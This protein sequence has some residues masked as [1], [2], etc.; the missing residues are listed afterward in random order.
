LN[1]ITKEEENVTEWLKDQN[2]IVFS[3]K[4][5][6]TPL[7]FRRDSFD[8]NILQLNHIL[9][10]CDKNDS[11]YAKQI[12]KNVSNT[13][14]DLGMFN[15]I[16]GTV[17]NLEKFS[18]ILSEGQT[19]SVKENPEINLS[20]FNGEMRLKMNDFNATFVEYSGEK[21]YSH[22]THHLVY[23]SDNITIDEMKHIAI[24]DQFFME[25]A[26]RTTD[27]KTKLY[28][29]MDSPYPIAEGETMTVPNYISTTT[30]LES[31]GE[32]RNGGVITFIDEY[33]YRRNKRTIM[34]KPP[35]LPDNLHNCCAY[36]LILDKDIPYVDME[37][38]TEIVS[39]KE[40]LLPR[41]LLITLI[42]EYITES[43]IHVRQLRVSKTTE[44]QFD[45]IPKNRCTKFGYADVDVA[46]IEFD[47]SSGGCRKSRHQKNK[48]KS[49][50]KTKKITTKTHLSVNKK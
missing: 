16:D 48:K 8:S 12:I 3:V 15:I 49:K 27:N 28:R 20:L 10:K 2:N 32:K 46:I 23:G 22:I 34:E 44:N 41:N 29:G 1:P 30:F 7:C 45:I 26:T 19:F 50:N 40:I 6:N 14:L 11:K 31:K 24:M 43:N 42:G 47:N 36:E 39:E 21:L 13:F 37:H 35:H 9:Y 38:S 25:H 5:N 17:T 18:K 4:G 33:Y